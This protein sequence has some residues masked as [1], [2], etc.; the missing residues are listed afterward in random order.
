MKPKIL[1]VLLTFIAIY[2]Y[3]ELSYLG[4]DDMDEVVSES[5]NFKKTEIY[6]QT[7]ITA[8]FD[9][10]SPRGDIS[11]CSKQNP[12]KP[13][14]FYPCWNSQSREFYS[15]LSYVVD[16]KSKKTVKT[17]FSFALANDGRVIDLNIKG[18]EDKPTRLQLEMLLKSMRFGHT[19]HNQERVLLT[20]VS[21]IH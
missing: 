18:I 9:V 15:K 10:G 12:R 11:N 21:G 17:Q 2:S 1:A 19:S 20:I 5:M 4:L 7:Q 13:M 3:A 14:S 16:A 8:N 6:H